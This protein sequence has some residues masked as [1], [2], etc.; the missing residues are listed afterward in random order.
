MNQEKR[1]PDLSTNVP[2]GPQAENGRSSEDVEPESS[3]RER[4]NESVERAPESQEGS[5]ERTRSRFEHV[6]QGA[7]GAAQ[8]LKAVARAAAE[9]VKE[10]FS[11]EETPTTLRTG[12]SKQASSIERLNDFVRGELAS[13]ETY[14]LALRAVQDSEL[15]GALRQIRD[16]HDRRVTMLRERIRVLGGEPAFS[17]GVWGAFARAIQRGADLLGHR[18]ALAALE[19]GEDQCKRRYARDIDE[20]EGELREFVLRELSIEQARTHDLARSLQKFVKAA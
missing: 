7:K 2:H 20:L 17:S 9:N 6:A 4:E 15:T 13:V 3:R 5:I 18:V 19:E 1:Q 12:E 11:R 14:D 8:E 10:S 16:S